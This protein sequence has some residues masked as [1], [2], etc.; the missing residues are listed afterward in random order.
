MTVTTGWVFSSKSLLEAGERIYNLE[1]ILAVWDGVTRK[2]DTLPPR[3]F[4][5]TLPTGPGQKGLSFRRRI[6]TECSSINFRV[7][8]MCELPPQWLTASTTELAQLS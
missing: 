6:S 4:E 5:E 7:G 2:D 8:L 3:V 1:R